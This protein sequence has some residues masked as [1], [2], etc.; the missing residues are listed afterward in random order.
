[1]RV[2]I[3]NHLEQIWTIVREK[4]AELFAWVTTLDIAIQVGAVA[5][6]FFFARWISPHFDRLIQRI[7]P[8][9]LPRPSLQS[10]THLVAPLE[11]PFFWLVSL[12][13]LLL[14]AGAFGLGFGLAAAVASL[15]VAWIVIRLMSRLVRNPILSGLIVILCWGLA[16]LAILNLLDPIARQL[17]ALAIHL[18]KLRLSALLVIQGLF[19]LGILLWLMTAFSDFLEKRI[20]KTKALTPSLQALFIQLSRF[21]FPV[22]AILV[23]LA[24]IG[25][26]LTAFTVFSGAIGVGIGLGLQ[27]TVTNFFAGLSLIMGKSIERGDVIA[28]TSTYGAVVEMGARY[29]TVQTRDGITHHVPNNY[30]ITNGVEN[31]SHYGNDVLRLHVGVGVAYH[32]DLEKAL[33][34]CVEAALATERVLALPAPVCLLKEFGESAIRL[35]LRFWINDPI[36]GVSNVKSAVMLAIWSSFRTAGIH[37]P[38]P[39]RNIRIIPSENADGPNAPDGAPAG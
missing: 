10:V 38:Y 33:A 24:I 2:P 6:A 14:I 27:S 34:L 36:N 35:D 15:L 31:W 29:V 25:V 26:D 13:V 3:L 30:F 18:G 7:L 11:L 17:D 28:Y 1:V 12:C 8:M 4:F 23:S 22:V 21:I 32:S 5:L 20:I 19:I 9:H 16:A 39:Q 37:V